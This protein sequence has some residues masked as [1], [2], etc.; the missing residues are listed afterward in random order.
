MALRPLRRAPSLSVL[1]LGGLSL[2]GRPETRYHLAD[3]CLPLNCVWQ[4]AA[5]A[6]CGRSPHSWCSLYFPAT[7]PLSY[8][9]FHKR[10][11]PHWAVGA[12]RSLQNGQLLVRATNLTFFYFYFFIES[13]ISIIISASSH[14]CTKTNLSL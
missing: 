4:R 3:R 12:G 6:Q 13:V 1:D 7:T 10:C 5:A 9:C 2:A 14:S 8:S 11:E